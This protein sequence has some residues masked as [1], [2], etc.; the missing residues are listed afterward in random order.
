MNPENSTS[1]SYNLVPDE[2]YTFK[3]Y[4]NWIKAM[5]EYDPMMLS[6]ALFHLS[7]TCPEESSLEGL[8]FPFPNPDNPSEI[9]EID[10]RSLIDQTRGEIC[11][12]FNQIYQPNKSF[13]TYTRIPQQ[14]DPSFLFEGKENSSLER[15]LG[16][17]GYQYE[18]SP[19]EGQS[20]WRRDGSLL[21][22][23]TRYTRNY[24]PAEE[25]A[26]EYPF[27]VNRTLNQ[28]LE[29]G[30]ELLNSESAMPP[31]AESREIYQK[32]RLYNSKTRLDNDLA[33]RLYQ[34]ARQMEASRNF[35]K[36]IMTYAVTHNREA[37]LTSRS[38]PFENF[39]HAKQ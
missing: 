15:L 18:E 34:M 39:W 7:N 33:I 27:F 21:F 36:A 12:K 24:T 23:T 32:L 1:D 26:L 4:L 19:I 8:A 14:N 22:L 31:T 28:A 37:M 3:G 16:N 35:F 30:T 5:E 2:F 17:I 10:I 25:T 29:F 9:I 11:S 20:M 38:Y 6:A 13:L